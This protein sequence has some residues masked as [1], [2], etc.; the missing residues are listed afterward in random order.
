MFPNWKPAGIKRAAASKRNDAKR[1]PQLKAS[2]YKGV[3][4][5]DVIDC[6]KII[7]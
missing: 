2:K 5:L 6:P 7:E 4:I 1:I 3:N